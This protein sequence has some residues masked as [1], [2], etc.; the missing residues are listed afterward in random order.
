MSNPGEADATPITS[1]GQLA[2]YIAAGCK[3]REQWR[4]G[5]EHEKFGFRRSD[6]AAPP[7]EPDGVHALLDG[8]AVRGWEPILD[9]G[10][11]I[12]L[13]GEGAS[14]ALEPGGQLELSGAT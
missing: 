5:T 6:L 13:K 7:Y 11:P 10:N 12:G 2:E 3:P 8:M 9:H 14:I 1:V 4:I